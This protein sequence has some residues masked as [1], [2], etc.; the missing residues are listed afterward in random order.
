[1]RRAPRRPAIPLLAALLLPLATAA[2]ALDSIELVP[3]ATSIGQVPI[4]VAHAPGDPGRLYVATQQGRILVWDGAAFL[5]TPF[6]DISSIVNTSHG[7]QGLLGFAFH[8]DYAANGLLYVHYTNQPAGDSLI[9]RFAR[10]ATDPNRADATSGTLVLFV[11]QPY[12]NHNGGQ[13][14]FGPDGFLY[15]GFGDGGGGGDP[16]ENA[17]NLG[18][19]LGKILR[20]DVDGGAPYAI[21]PSNPFVG[22]A[23]AR[24]E[25][26]A[27]GLRHPW[28]FD[29]DPRTGD[30]WIGDVGQDAIE[31]VNFEP[32]GSGGGRNY[33]WDRME[34]S[35]CFEPATGC[36]D[37]TLTLP[38]IE[39]PNAGFAECSV[40]GGN[41][42]RGAQHP[43]LYGRYVYADAC[44]GRFWTAR[45]DGAGGFVAEEA[46][47]SPVRPSTFGSDA[48]G[49]LYVG[50]LRG[51]FYRLR[52]PSPACDVTVL[53][54][55]HGPGDVVQIDAVR[56]RNP[57]AFARPVEL[58]IWLR[59]P[60]VAP[61]AA[62][63]GGANGG[64]SLAPGFDVTLG[65]FPLFAVGGA[66]TPGRYEFGC[67]LLEPATGATYAGASAGF[68]ITP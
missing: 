32:A 37:G 15:L 62:V 22:V 41:V 10:S 65:P 19:L 51:G 16:N 13:V 63:N 60:G 57:G 4:V 18:S 40:I 43:D 8:P 56:I 21:P 23:G 2:R 64:L 55:E 67:T 7:E 47:V 29:F 50:D 3:V 6:L 52:A 17:E 53:D 31:E 12:P 35:L 1:M 11:D 48:A 42:Y 26:W 44:S 46:L 68:A 24:E 30:L 9:V 58:K 5:P 33:G 54:T 61:F 66:T 38:V 20:I 27:Y 45:P 39:Y 14:V 34:G 49:E 28:R 25:V 36:N 59:A